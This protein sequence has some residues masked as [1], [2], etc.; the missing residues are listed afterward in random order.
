MW[1]FFRCRQELNELA[2]LS[3]TCPRFY[4][5]R[6]KSKNLLTDDGLHPGLD[7]PDDGK[8]GAKHQ[9]HQP[10]VEDDLVGERPDILSNDMA[11]DQADCSQEEGRR[12]KLGG[13]LDAFIHF[14]T[15]DLFPVTH[16]VRS[17]TAQ[18]GERRKHCR[19]HQTHDHENGHDGTP[20]KRRI[21]A[22]VVATTVAV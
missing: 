18:D 8:P 17:G 14:P 1:T 13:R 9:G 7:R 21:V 4:S 5:G 10:Q 3:A 2:R 22:P 16:D 12:Q 20:Q 15:L 11:N 19:E 6:K